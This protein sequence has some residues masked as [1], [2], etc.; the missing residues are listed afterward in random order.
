MKSLYTEI[1]NDH[2]IMIHLT[3][4]TIYNLK[5]IIFTF[6][7]FSLVVFL[8]YKEIAQAYFLNFEFEDK[9][10]TPLL[11]LIWVYYMFYILCHG[12]SIYESIALF[13]F[14]NLII[15]KLLL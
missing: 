10:L 6:P 1:I 13:G 8:Y 3:G 5:Y 4:M 15:V 2:K 14:Y 7:V 11:S 9:S 12:I